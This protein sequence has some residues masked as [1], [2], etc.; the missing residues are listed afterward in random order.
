[1]SVLVVQI[2]PRKRLG[3]QPPA[4]AEASGAADAGSGFATAELM[5]VRTENGTTVQSQGH[6]TANRLPMAEAVV[7]V[8]SEQDV[9]WHSLDVPRAPAGKLRAALLGMLEEGVLSEPEQL[10]VALAPQARAGSRGWVAVLE[11]AWLAE[12]IGTI[13]RRGLLVDRVV[14]ALAPGDLARGHFFDA[15]APGQ[16]PE[17]AIAMADA[18][19]IVC[20]PLNGTL[21]RAL[22]PPAAAQAVRWTAPPAVA[23]AAERWLGAPVKLQTVTDR[24]LEAARSSWNLRQF[25]LVARR[26]GALALRDAGRRFLRPTWKPVRIGLA[27]AVALQVIA[28]NLWAWMHRHAVDDKRQAQTALLLSAHPNVR[29]VRDAPLQMERETELLRAAAGKPGA[30]DLEVLLAAA[31]AAWPDNQGP[32]QSLRFQPGQLSLATQGWRP[33]ELK[34]FGERLRP[35]GWAVETQAGLVKISRASAP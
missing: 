23:A 12:A 21:A 4:G 33:E 11:K 28:L 14:P 16:T 22:L 29:V 19:G 7:L 24:L 32:M 6:A 3:P 9:S 25:D 20:L 34:Q 17:P 13:E 27:V 10:H 1:M 2:P 26:R 15:A 18:N 35:A 5:W 30:G 31:A 8:L